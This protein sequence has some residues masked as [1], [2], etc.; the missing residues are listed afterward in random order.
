MSMDDQPEEEGKK[1][2]VRKPREKTD[3]PKRQ[4]TGDYEVGYCRTP[5]STR[6]QKDQSGNERGSS[7][8]ARRRKAAEPQSLAQKL[9]EIVNKSVPLRVNGRLENVAGVEAMMLGL[10]ANASK[11]SRIAQKDV[12]NF[13]LQLEAKAVSQVTDL[14]STMLDYKEEWY[15]LAREERTKKGL[16]PPLPHPDDIH[17]DRYNGTVTI[18]GPRCQEELEWFARLL[19]NREYLAGEIAA[20]EAEIEEE[21]HGGGSRDEFQAQTVALFNKQLRKIDK[22]IAQT[23]WTPRIAGSAPP[24][25]PPG[26]ME[27]QVELRALIGLDL[28]TR[29]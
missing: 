22:R 1:K 13:A 7:E 14:F 10:M 5:K 15:P 8:K 21:V 2:P 29:A 18:T 19:A 3:R 20:L 17:L 6:W 26:S 11:G 4:P 24:R 25:H 28:T 27:R 12:I 23:G 16:P 9:L